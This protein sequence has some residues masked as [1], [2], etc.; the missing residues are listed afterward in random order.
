MFGAT[1]DK[2]IAH[3]VLFDEDDHTPITEAIW[4]VLNQCF[5]KVTPEFEAIKDERN[6]NEI[7][8]FVG[9]IL[10]RKTKEEDI[11]AGTMDR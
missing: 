10:T 11:R 5:Q 4:N 7:L 9:Q 1:S 2:Q 3:Y 8:F 6:Q